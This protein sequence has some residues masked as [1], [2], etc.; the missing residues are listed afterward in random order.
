MAGLHLLR[1]LAGPLHEFGLLPGLVYG[2][3]RVLRAVS[4]RLGI[5]WYELMAQPVTARPLLPAS[6]G[7]GLHFRELAPGDA[8]LAR[9]PVPAPVIA[10]RFAQQAVCLA[11]HL[12]EAFV[13]YIWLRFGSYDEDEVR[14]RFEPQPAGRT[15]F[16]FDMYVFPD[17]RLGIA[18]AAVWQAANSHLQS[19]G[20]SHTC[21]RI[22]RFNEASRRA[23]RRLGALRVGQA[24]FFQAGSVEAMVATTSPFF[25]VSIGGSRVR[26]PI[27]APPEA[28]PVAAGTD[29][30]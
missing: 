12:R 5:Y 28:V 17:H 29:R 21:S 15:A 6:I 27:P 26:L 18:F 4:P 2:L 22:T 7:R 11:V 14:C 3:D 19:R 8:E 9:M 24:L 25:H 20:V 16:D 1:R 13:G 23:H 30:P 10:A